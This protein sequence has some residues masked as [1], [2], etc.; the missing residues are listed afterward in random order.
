MKRALTKAVGWDLLTLSRAERYFDWHWEMYEQLTT[1]LSGRGIWATGAYPKYPTKRETNPSLGERSWDNWRR[2][3]VKADEINS[4]KEVR[5]SFEGGF[6]IVRT[7]NEAKYED[8]RD[9]HKAVQKNCC[10]RSWRWWLTF[11][12]INT[13]KMGACCQRFQ[14]FVT[15]IWSLF[16]MKSSPVLRSTFTRT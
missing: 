6:R 5:S 9:C 7:K 4:Y 2:E 15:V 12:L 14:H 1:S 13:S 10:T 8:Q 16:Y 11:K 3:S